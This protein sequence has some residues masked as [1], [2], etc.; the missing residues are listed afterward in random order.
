MLFN[1]ISKEPH[2]G[3]DLNG[4]DVARKLTILSRAIPTLRTALPAGYKSV[5]TTSLVPGELEGVATGDEFIQRL[6]AFDAHFDVMRGEAAAEGKV[7][8]YVGVVDVESGEIRASLEKCVSIVSLLFFSCF[9][10]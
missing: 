3:D 2:P 1:S 6:P 9:F 4:A 10:V 5:H 8:R 7:L